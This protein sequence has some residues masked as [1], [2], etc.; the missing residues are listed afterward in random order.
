MAN[1][2]NGMTF[3]NV[4]MEG[5]STLEQ[6]LVPL[7]GFTL[8]LSANIAQQG[9]AVSTRI[10]PAATASTDL[11]DAES[12]SYAAVTDDQTTT[13]V[14]VTLDPHPVTG[15]HFT[16]SEAQNI[17][18][19]VW[20]DT[21]RRLV[22]SHIRGIA[23]DVL[24]TTFALITNANYGA[25]A[26]TTTAANFDADDVA[27]LRKTAVNAGMDPN[28]AVLVVNPDYYAALLKDA[29]IQDYSASQSD[30]LRTGQ[31]PRLSGFRVIE[32]PTLPGNSENLVGFIA[33]SDAIAIAMRGVDTQDRSA[34]L[35]YDILQSDAVG[36]VMTYS[37]VYTAETTRRVNHIFEALYGVAKGQGASLKR[38]VSA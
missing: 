18:A 16:D 17:G 33:Q 8:D 23:E 5:I 30:A 10:V 13:A 9:T 35:A 7:A 6:H 3:T 37:A 34:F 19:G 15:F 2:F 31:L 11:V 1:T 12:G 22:A 28:D 26:L 32:A 38:I 24:D 14:T 25:A 21:S 36:A 29:A 4:A 20:A 27:D